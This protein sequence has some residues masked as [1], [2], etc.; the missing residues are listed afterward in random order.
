MFPNTGNKEKP[1]IVPFLF[2]FSHS[3]LNAPLSPQAIHV[4]KK[5]YTM[6][7]CVTEENISRIQSATAYRPLSQSLQK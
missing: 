3:I 4:A 1:P 2:F 7:I 6:D 5:N